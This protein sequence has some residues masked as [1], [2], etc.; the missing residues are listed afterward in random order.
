MDYRRKHLERFTFFRKST[1]RIFIEFVPPITDFKSGFSGISF[2]TFDIP[3]NG[4]LVDM[5]N[6]MKVKYDLY[7]V[8]EDREKK[9]KQLREKILSIKK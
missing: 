1:H 5:V 9:I 3:K 2:D 6:E 7:T 4:T 8:V